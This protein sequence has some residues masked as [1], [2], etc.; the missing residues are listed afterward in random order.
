ML[1]NV[2]WSI[3]QSSQQQEG[4]FLPRVNKGTGIL[5][6]LLI[7]GSI[8]GSLL[9]EMLSGILPFLAF[10]RTVGLSPATID[11]TPVVLTLGL[12]LKLNIATIIGFF[13]TL[14]IYLRL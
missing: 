9:G 10:G 7:I 11:L 14:F 13:I 12:T 8:F 1:Q 3:D 2:E 6:I 5:I 4:N